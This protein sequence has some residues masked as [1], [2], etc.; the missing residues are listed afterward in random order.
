MNN[1]QIDLFFIKALTNMHV[2]S[3]QNDL[4]IIDNLVQRDALT[5]YPTINSSSLKGALRQFF[6]HVMGNRHHPLITSCF[7]RDMKDVDSGEGNGGKA[8]NQAGQFI[9]FS[10]KLLSIPVRSNVRPFFRATCPAILEQLLVDIEAFGYDLKEKEAIKAFAQS[11]GDDQ[12]AV[13]FDP[14]ITGEVYLEMLD[15]KASP[16]TFDQLTIIETLLGDGL[17]L[18]SDEKFENLVSNA[19]LPVVARNHLENGI[20]QN[21]WYEQIIPRQTQFYTLILSPEGHKHG[22]TFKENLKQP[23]QIGGNASI[24][25]GF[26]HFEYQ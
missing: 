12:D 22:S 5:N 23:V 19:T 17:V 1:Y 7:G 15:L 25:Y 16:N 18:L 3:G 8:N 20:S 11:L 26:C 2:G 14:S 21:L 6:C 4:G 13:Y 24:G 10:G 9:F